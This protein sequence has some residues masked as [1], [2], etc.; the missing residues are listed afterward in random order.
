MIPKNNQFVGLKGTH[1]IA[2]YKE[3]SIK[4][5]QGNPHIE[6]LPNRLNIEEYIDTLSSQPE[7]T[8]QDINLGVE[9]RLELIQQIKPNFWLPFPQHYDKYRSLYTMIKIGYQSRNPL[10]AMY[11]RQFAIGWDK[12]FETGID[13]NGA[14]LAGNVQT[15]QSHVEI[16][17]SGSG[18]SKIYER[19]LSQ[20]FPQ[21]IHH[22]EYKGRSLNHPQV[23]WLKIECP[24]NKSVGSL[25]KSFYSAVDVV[26][27]T[28]YYEKFGEKPGKMDQLAKRMIKVAAQINLGVLVIDEIQKIQKAYSGGKEDLIDFITEIVNTIGIPIILIGSYKALYLFKD[29]LA[30]TRRGIP[31]E[32]MES[33]SGYMLQNSWEWDEFIENLWDLQYTRKYSQ[34]TPR[35]KEA[36]YD[37]TLGIPDFAVKL[38]MHVQSRA[39]VRGG[40]EQLSENLIREVAGQSMKLVQPIFERIRSGEQSEFMK[41]EDA[42]PDWVSLNEYIKG[43]THRMNVYGHLAKDH[44]RILQQKN[45]VEILEKLTAFALHLVQPT[46]IAERIVNE[47]Y[48]ASEGMGDLTTMLGQIAQ[49]AMDTIPSTIGEVKKQTSDVVSE[50]KPTKKIKPALQEK[51]LRY[52]V[53]SGHKRG[54]TTEE[55]LEEKEYVRREEE[56]LDFMSSW[57][58]DAI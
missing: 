10:H 34:L 3:Q 51:D 35:I 32:Y 49:L 48:E 7:I 54:L 57:K 12:I 16:A 26:L 42:V 56:L 14:N 11:N 21:V 45:K 27:G 1:C 47:V 25:C 17:I 9:D 20:L 19:T 30:N 52:I 6:A 53:Q 58:G 2:E 36:M 22:N 33:I 23:V 46:Q 43:V 8:K 13:E 24:Y 4:Q 39:I 18:K 41:L 55:A 44:S 50:M 28:N 5:Y 29:S 40:D 37:N 38:F 31:D 15:A